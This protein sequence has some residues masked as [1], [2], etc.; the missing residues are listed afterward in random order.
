MAALGVTS[1][2]ASFARSAEA[3][4]AA[5]TAA[6][7]TLGIVG[8]AFTMNGQGPPLLSALSMATPHGWFLRGLADLHGT[9]ASVLACLP[10]V[11]VLVSVGVVTGGA[12]MMRAR[13]L[14]AVR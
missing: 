12:G 2:V 5:C 13:R 9:G 7:M 10:A 1:L 6:A 14:V 8:G 4:G 11:A 3:A